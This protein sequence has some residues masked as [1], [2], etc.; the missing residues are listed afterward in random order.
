[1]LYDHLLLLAFCVCDVCVLSCREHPN[2]SQVK[3]EFQPNEDS[4]LAELHLAST[5]MGVPG[6][7]Q[8]LLENE[9]LHIDR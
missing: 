8:I 2:V 9:K 5:G 1:M 6:I 7:D 4:L 3:E